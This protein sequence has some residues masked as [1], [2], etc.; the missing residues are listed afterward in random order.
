MFLNLLTVCLVRLDW[1]S[2]WFRYVS[3]WLKLAITMLTQERKVACFNTDL[4]H[5]S[6]GDNVMEESSLMVEEWKHW[7]ILWVF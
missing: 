1:F 4:G 6:H 5:I 3:L 2:S 7:R